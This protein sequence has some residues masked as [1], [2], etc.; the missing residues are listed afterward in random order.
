MVTE[1]RK[2]LDFDRFWMEQAFITDADWT[3][4]EQNGQVQKAEINFTS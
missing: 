4:P 3:G 2:L 1:W